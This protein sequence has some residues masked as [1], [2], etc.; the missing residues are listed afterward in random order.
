MTVVKQRIPLTASEFSRL[1]RQVARLLATSRTPVVLPGEAI[2][3]IEAIAAGVAAP[4]RR[5]L[6]LVTGPYGDQFG[7]WLRRRGAEVLDLFCG[8]DEVI[9]VQDAAAAVEAHRPAV[10]AFVQAESATG[11]TNP[12]AALMALA[13]DRG[14]VTVIDAVSAV[15]A[16][17][18]CFD[19]WGADFL[20]VGAQKALA[21]PNGVSAVA[22]SE[23][24]WALLESTPSAPRDSHLSLLDRKPA[25]DG[26]VPT[27][28]I[29]V[30][31]ARALLEAL[32]LV[33]EEGLA[34]VQ[35][36]HR[37]SSSAARAALGPLGLEPWQRHAVGC[38]AVTTTVRIPPSLR[39]PLDSAIGIVTPGDGALRGKLFRI[40]HFGANARLEP[41]AA[42]ITTIAGLAGGKGRRGSAQ[43]RPEGMERGRRWT[44]SGRTCASWSTHHFRAYSSWAAAAG[45]LTSRSV[46]AASPRYP[47]RHPEPWMGISG[48]ARDSSTCTRTSR[49]RIFTMRTN[50]GERLPRWKTF[51]PWRSRRPY[52][53]ESRPSGMRAA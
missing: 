4:G 42:A 48:S 27:A 52:G 39:L 3:G 41:L 13:R 23:R 47:I 32:D 17:P 46:T 1:R 24:G 38:A 12:T 44:I 40:N 8:F 20:V 49:G 11:G 16:E 14:L 2:L 19:D 6:N 43:R 26:D 30:L 37:R 50:C 21:G 22:I 31:E 28:D 25:G 15:G 53:P 18:I 7:R 33:E 51:S 36:R 9:R 35:R 5:V 10:L 29:P 45:A 34:S